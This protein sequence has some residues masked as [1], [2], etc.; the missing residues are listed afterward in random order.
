MRLLRQ[1]KAG[2]SLTRLTHF[3]NRIVILQRARK[4]HTKRFA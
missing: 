2:I 3:N 4:F 1:R